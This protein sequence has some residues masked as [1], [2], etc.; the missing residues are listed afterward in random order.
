MLTYPVFFGSLV[1]LFAAISAVNAYCLDR[2]ELTVGDVQ[3]DID[4]VV[5][6]LG[7]AKEEILAE[8]GALEVAVSEGEVLD[9]S[10]LKAAAQ[11]LDDVVVDA[12]VVE[13]EEVV[14]EG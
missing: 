4:A 7:R 12:P 2:M 3:S 10:G 9:L 8:I 14:V 13:S 6:Q 11:A 1:L 5:E